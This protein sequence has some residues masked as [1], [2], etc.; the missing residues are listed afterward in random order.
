MDPTILVADDDAVIADRLVEILNGHGF[1]LLSRP[2]HPT[3]L[4]KTL[5]TPPR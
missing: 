1:S 3:L 2:I 4:L 5:R